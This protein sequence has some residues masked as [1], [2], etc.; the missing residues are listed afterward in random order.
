M[1]TRHELRERRLVAH[2]GRS[3]DLGALDRHRVHHAIEIPPEAG[4]IQ[5]ASDLARARAVESAWAV[6]TQVSLPAD[7]P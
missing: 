5:A 1:M 3:H 4:L 7:A 2:R 6:P